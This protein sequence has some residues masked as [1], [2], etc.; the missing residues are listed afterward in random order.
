MDFLSKLYGLFLKKD[1][2]RSDFVRSGDV[3]PGDLE[4][5]LTEN[6]GEEVEVH[7]INQDIPRILH[8][9][10]I[11]LSRNSFY[12]GKSEGQKYQINLHKKDFSS[13]IDAVKMIKT[14]AGEILYENPDIDFD[15]SS[16]KTD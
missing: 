8:D 9:K 13:R 10:I 6:I 16:A 14:T 1:D 3:L 12:L 4:K 7:Y 2:S 11:H 5:K 15:Y